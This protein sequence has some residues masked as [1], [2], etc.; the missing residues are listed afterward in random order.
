[1]GLLLMMSMRIC[2]VG[3]VVVSSF[4]LLY[5]SN[6]MKPNECFGVVEGNVL[7]LCTTTITQHLPG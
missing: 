6:K 7:T 4:S 5:V 1:M 2:N 3:C